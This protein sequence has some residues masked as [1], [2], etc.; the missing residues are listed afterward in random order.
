MP[1]T[2]DYKYNTD[3]IVKDS[4]PFKA[5]DGSY[6]SSMESVDKANRDYWTAFQSFA[7]D[8][9]K[10][11]VPLTPRQLELIK[12]NPD[13]R[14]LIQIIH[15]TILLQEQSLDDRPKGMGR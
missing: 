11:D 13:Y 9:V 1:Y 12:N 10:L 3:Y 4:T 14:S 6:H 15:E 5:I 7:C 2:G 8:D